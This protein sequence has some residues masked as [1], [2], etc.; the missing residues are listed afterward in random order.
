MF[1]RGFSFFIG[2]PVFL[3][4]KVLKFFFKGGFPNELAVAEGLQTYDYAA[5]GYLVVIVLVAI[6]GMIFQFK[7][8]KR[9]EKAEKDITANREDSISRERLL[10]DDYM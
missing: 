3:V 8:K 1:V 6:G 7:R 5:Y 4:Y 2:K 9:N 10:Q